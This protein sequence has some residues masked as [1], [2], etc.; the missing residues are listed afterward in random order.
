MENLIF[1]W[2]VITQELDKFDFKMN[3]IPNVLEKYTS[4]V[5]F[6]SFLFFTSSLDSLVNN[7][8]EK[9]F[10]HLSQKFDSDYPCEYM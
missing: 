4:L 7:L 1:L 9:D 6:D 3:V 5:I 2:S 8:Y 10:K